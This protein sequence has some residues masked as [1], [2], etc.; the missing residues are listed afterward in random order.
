MG[1]TRFD[2][3]KWVGGHGTFGAHVVGGLLWTQTPLSKNDLPLQS[4][5]KPTKQITQY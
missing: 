2:E 4:N 3:T 1:T 5:P